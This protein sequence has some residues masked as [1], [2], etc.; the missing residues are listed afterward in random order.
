M[1]VAVLLSLAGAAVAQTTSGPLTT[2][3]APLTSQQQCVV[4]KCGGSY[5]DVNCVAS[6]FGVPSPDDPM[7]DQTNKCY[8]SCVD[9]KL[10]GTEAEVCITNCIT[11]YYNPAGGKVTAANSSAA[12]SSATSGSASTGSSGSAASASASASKSGASSGSSSAASAESSTSASPASKLVT[13]FSAASVITALGLSAAA[14][15]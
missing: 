10:E 2:S 8:A 11:Q 3:E 14:L 4:S 15:L 5:A 1:K 7:V 13:N 6:C 12:T 9:K